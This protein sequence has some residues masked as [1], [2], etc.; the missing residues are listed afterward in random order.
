MLAVFRFVFAMHMLKSHRMFSQIDIV[1]F[2]GFV[3]NRFITILY[4]HTKRI[5]PNC[6]SQANLFFSVEHQARQISNDLLS[7]MDL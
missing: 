1:Q 2:V 5:T 3:F 6:H 4:I 7:V